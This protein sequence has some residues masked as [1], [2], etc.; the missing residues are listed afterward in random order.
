MPG[1]IVQFITEP[2]SS[3]FTL[4]N[5]SEDESLALTR[6]V[7][8]SL[9]IY[10]T[11]IHLIKRF[12][13]SIISIY[14]KIRKFCLNNWPKIS[15][16]LV[17]NF[18]KEYITDEIYFNNFTQ[19]FQKFSSIIAS[20]FEKSDDINAYLFLVSSSEFLSKK[21]IAFILKKIQN[22]LSGYNEGVFNFTSECTGLA[23]S[24]CNFEEKIDTLLAEIQ[25][26]K[27]DSTQKTIAYVNQ[28]FDDP[29][30]DEIGKFNQ[31]CRELMKSADIISDIIE[32]TLVLK[33]LNI[34]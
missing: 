12:S 17:L 4:Q 32:Q 3:L 21:K 26:D 14:P 28:V 2:G 19:I 23:L 31:M 5:L 20:K 13:K 18:I 6:A 7:I 25:Y 29:N 16:N 30:F 33:A 11:N 22:Q 8:N 15:T 10:P 34:I 27:V 9:V 24:F 1:K